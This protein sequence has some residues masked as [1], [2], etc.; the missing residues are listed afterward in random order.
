MKNDIDPETIIEKYKDSKASISYDDLYEIGS[1]ATWSL[2]S[3]KPGN[4]LENLR[5]DELG[6]YWQSDGSQPHLVNIQFPKKVFVSQISLQIDH[7][8]DESYTPSKITVR[9]GTNFADLQDL[10]TMELSE[11][12][13]W[14][15]IQLSPDL[16]KNRPIGAHLFQIC[17]KSNHQNGKDTRIRQIKVFAPKLKSVQDDLDSDDEMPFRTIEF[18]MHAT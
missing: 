3:W 4:D 11:P 5:D 16:M 8:Q 1:L 2:S 18:K 6:T 17:I 13:G 10:R 7:K 9:A 15:D 12:T 14:I